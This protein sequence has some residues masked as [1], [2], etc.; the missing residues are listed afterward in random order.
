VAQLR[1]RRKPY[2]WGLDGGF[3]AAD[4]PDLDHCHIDLSGSHAFRSP[5]H[6]L[7]L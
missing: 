7:P 3:P 4:I 1:E 2:P 6:G 5:A